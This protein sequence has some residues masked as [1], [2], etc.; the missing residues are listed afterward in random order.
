MY[1]AYTSANGKQN[2]NKVCRLL[3]SRVDL[4]QIQK[5]ELCCG[6]FGTNAPN[7]TTE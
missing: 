4:W 6:L 7:N 3:E 5:A 2:E 1:V